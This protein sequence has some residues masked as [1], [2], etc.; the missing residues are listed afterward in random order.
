MQYTTV[1]HINEAY[2][3]I[4]IESFPT[5]F[6]LTCSASEESSEYG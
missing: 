3:R 6:Q 2:Y 5:S 1:P 4:L